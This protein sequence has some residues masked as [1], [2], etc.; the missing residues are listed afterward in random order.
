MAVA[1]LFSGGFE[2]VHLTHPYLLFIISDFI[3]EGNKKI[4]GRN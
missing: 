1:L 4:L 3:T 2:V